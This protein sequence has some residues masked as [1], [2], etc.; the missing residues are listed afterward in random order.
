MIINKKSSLGFIVVFS[1]LLILGILLLKP[2]RFGLCEVNDSICTAD[3][4]ETFAQPIILL[5]AVTL[6]FLFVGFFVSQEI[7][8]PW[9]KFALSYLLISIILLATTPTQC[10]APLSY[11]VDREMLTFG[12][13][14]LYFAVSVILILY[15]LFRLRSQ[16]GL[17][18][19]KTSS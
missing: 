11:C 16:K 5:S 1:T 3:S 6:F 14:I 13:S 19:V 2:Q 18:G 15:K 8:K 10:H 17:V 9:K 12:L 4:V 7:I